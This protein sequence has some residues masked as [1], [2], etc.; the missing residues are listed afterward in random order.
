MSKIR[1]RADKMCRETSP[2]ATPPSSPSL[3]GNDGRVTTEVKKLEKL[4]RGWR[5][6]GKK[7]KGVDRISAKSASKSNGLGGGE[8]AA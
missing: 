3:G 5:K 1:K 8:G 2:S 4:G 7:T 6:K